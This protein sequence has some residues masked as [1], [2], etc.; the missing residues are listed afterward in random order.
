MLPE[1]EVVP[2]P[3]VK[4]AFLMKTKR[5]ISIIAACSLLGTAAFSVHAIAQEHLTQ[6][7]AAVSY[8]S[9][10]LA[11]YAEQVAVLVNQERAANGL[12]PLKLSPLLSE[13]ANIRSGEL[14]ENFSHTRPDGTSCFTVMDELGISYRAAAENIAYGQ[15][16]PESVMHGWMNSS[17]HRANIL[18]ENVDYI[19]VGV[20]YRDGI[21]YWTQ[22]FA[23]S[24]DLSD[25]A[26]L[27]GEDAE[28]P[29]VTTTAPMTT[30]Q[31]TT[32]TSTTTATTT[33][34]TTTEQT[35]A[36]SPITTEQT[37][38]TETAATT[39]EAVQ[40]TAD[41]PI[42]TTAVSTETEP[43]ATTQT[44]VS[45]PVATE[46]TTTTCRTETTTD[47]VVITKPVFTLPISGDC[48]VIGGGALVVIAPK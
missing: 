33:E 35:A 34:Q 22:L 25:G 32:T 36:S 47:C 2:T 41:A 7:T 28:P 16:S 26:Y 17:G 24:G 11:E 29:A 12:Q 44:T 6:D 45:Q 20:V 13:A 30:V 19:G 5:I 39:S 21:Y 10:E 42:T 14:K 18:S 40:T 38:T 48:S 37:A 27:P 43:P 1:P 15:R 8:D 23:A 9:P 4:E 3:D 31:T 46:G